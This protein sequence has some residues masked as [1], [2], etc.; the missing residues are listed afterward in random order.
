MDRSRFGSKSYVVLGL[1]LLVVSGLRMKKNNLAMLQEDVAI[2]ESA[3]LSGGEFLI[4]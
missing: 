1:Q 4:S 2:A 3:S